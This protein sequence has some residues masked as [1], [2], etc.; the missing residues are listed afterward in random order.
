MDYIIIKN[1]GLIVKEDLFLIGSSTKR[2]D[3]SKIGMFGSGWKY[4]LAWFL[5]NQCTITIYSGTTKIDINTITVNHRDMLVKV[6][7]INGKQTS[8]T[9]EMGMKWTGWMA[10]REVISNAIDEGGFQLEIDGSLQPSDNTTTIYIGVNDELKDVIYNYDNYFS[11]NRKDGIVFNNVYRDGDVPFYLKTSLTPMNIYRKGIRCYEDNLK[12]TYFDIDISNA[13]INESRLCDYYSIDTSIYNSMKTTI[14]FDVIKAI[15]SSPEYD[16]DFLPESPTENVKIL[17]EEEVILG[18][19]FTSNLFI[20]LFGVHSNPNA[21]VIPNEWYRYLV[22]KGLIED[23]TIS[24]L[25]LD[26]PRDFLVK[27]VQGKEKVIE[28]VT[29]ILPNFTIIYGVFEATFE[30]I[31][32]V[33]STAYVKWDYRKGDDIPLAAEIIT[34]VQYGYWREILLSIKIKEEAL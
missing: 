15:L 9:T 25:G 8:L 11:F 7:T 4:A 10:L 19:V 3:D 26:A 30:T 29:K 2:E 20:K 6:I 27:E 24:L 32:V 17:L 34:K 13:D 12:D 22:Y 14:R 31:R 16:K 33:G 28:Y 23:E 1:K 21:I 18:T 5:R